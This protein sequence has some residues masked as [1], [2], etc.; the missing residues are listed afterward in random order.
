MVWNSS[1]SVQMSVGC[2]A[3]PVGPLFPPRRRRGEGGFSAAAIFC[4]KSPP[5]YRFA[6]NRFQPRGASSNP[7]RR[8]EYANCAWR[9]LPHCSGSKWFCAISSDFSGGIVSG[10]RLRNLV[11]GGSLLLGQIEHAANF[12]AS[13]LFFRPACPKSKMGMGTPP[14][15]QPASRIMFCMNTQCIALQWHPPGCPNIIPQCPQFPLAGL[16]FRDD[17]PVPRDPGGFIGR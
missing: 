12:A 3:I 16:K 14:L 9:A 1:Y 10:I 17:W 2:S 5:S 7:P 11:D 4:R 8:P 13:G 6:A 15:G